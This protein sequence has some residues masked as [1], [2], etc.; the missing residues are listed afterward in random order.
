MEKTFEVAFRVEVPAVDENKAVDIARRAVAERQSGVRV[1]T[2]MIHDG[3]NSDFISR[4]VNHVAVLGP[5]ERQRLEAI[6]SELV[7]PLH[8]LTEEQNK[9]YSEAINLIC[10]PR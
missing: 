9:L 4:E 1:V 2:G 10:W 6:L 5:R 8:P 3:L 7:L